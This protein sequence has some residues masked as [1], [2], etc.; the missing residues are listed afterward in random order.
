VKTALIETNPATKVET[1]KIRAADRNERRPFTLAELRKVLAVCSPEWRGIVLAGIYT[2]QRL[3]DL[4]TLTW[5]AVDLDQGMISF[6]TSKTGRRQHIPIAT[7]LRNY[8]ESLPA[9][10]N[11]RAFVFPKAAV[12]NRRSNQFYDILVDAGLA[13]ERSDE[14]TDNTGVGR[15]R[16]RIVNELSFHCIRHTAT[17]LL[18]VAG[19]SQAVV[20]DLIGHDSEAASR[21]YTHVHDD[22]KRAALGKLP[23]LLSK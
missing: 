22:D 20:M 4:A 10:D 23:D 6:V 3:G 8:L 2:G 11:P 21:G 14:N 13:K 17:S 9:A 7:P 1:I 15:K 16:R 12:S 5:S 19:V 18:K